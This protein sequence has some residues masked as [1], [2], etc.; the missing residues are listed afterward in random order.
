MDKLPQDTLQETSPAPQAAPAVPA[1]QPASGGSWW[2]SKKMWGVVAVLLIFLAVGTLVPVSKIP[3]LRNLVYAMGYTPDE[4]K[5]ISFLKAL[6]SWNDRSKMMR[7]EL[8]DPDEASIF[9]PD[10]GFLTAASLQAQNKLIDIQSVNAALARRGQKA[11]YLTGSYNAAPGEEE[12]SAGV[13]VANA[14]ASAGTQAN[15]ANKAEVFFGEDASATARDKN[16][17]FDSTNTLKKVANKPVAGGSGG[18]D[19]L[20][21]LVDKASRTDSNL[22]GLMQNLDRTGSTLANL[23][24]VGKIGDSHAKRDMY[25]AWLT[26]RAARR[27]PQIVLKKTLA[28]SGFNGAEMPRSV[29][30]ASGFSGVGIKPDDVV[31]DMDSVKKY[32]EQDKKCQ[33]ALSNGSSLSSGAFEDTGERIRGLSGSFPATCGDR[34]NSGFMAGLQGIANNCQQIKRSYE[35]VQTDCATISLNLQDSQCKA[36]KLTSYYTAFDSFCEDE[37]NKC[38]SQETP[39]A[40]EACVSQ[41]NQ[42]SSSEDYMEPG[43]NISYN[44]GELGNVIQETFY[45]DKNG[46][47]QDYFPGVDWGHSLWLDEDAAD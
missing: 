35:Q 10:G 21:R 47:N 45:D 2:Y 46:P 8:P 14:N 7:G 36:E 9:G 20:G 38:A 30:T 17:A 39:E 41:V 42:R 29:F 4:A 22:S 24:P 44:S 6:F 43:S 1:P 11:D 34:A 27:T 23:G 12:S 5:N 25:Y 3:F 26:G 32:L 13:R 16:D 37:L 18:D 40:Q 28:S 31:A 19:W 15:R 33:E